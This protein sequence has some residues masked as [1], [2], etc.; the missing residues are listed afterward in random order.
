MTIWRSKIDDCPERDADHPFYPEGY[1]E[2][3]EEVMAEPWVRAMEDLVKW[4]GIWVGTEEQFFAELEMR[5][6]KAIF[7]SPNFPSSIERL[8][9]YIEIAVEG[10]MQMDLTFFHYQEMSPED[11]A[12]FDVPEWGPEAPILVF[13]GRATSRPN[14]YRAMCRLLAFHQDALPLSIL[15]FTGE[16][17]HF[18]DSRRWSGTTTELIKKLQNNPPN[19]PGAMP[20]YFI[21]CFRPEEE[22]RSLP[23]F[24][25]DPPGLL[26]PW[27]RE[28]YIT[29]HQQM[30]RW[31]PVLREY[32][33]KISLQKR[34]F[35]WISPEGDKS[36]LRERTCWPIE[37]P[38]WKK[39]DDLFMDSRKVRNLPITVAAWI[40]PS[41]YDG[42]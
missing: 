41:N 31:A 5:V 21:D 25:F 16:D 29:F 37:A 20:M 11:L 9:L 10:F 30:K 17:R 33:I 32:G 12:D 23:D 40:A 8:N 2:W 28:D 42:A 39:P 27:H 15:L 7:A 24:H 35:R 19:Q 6:G 26:E 3:L 14:Y 18:K 38:R 22:H 36:E 4:T 1:D 13:A 34:P